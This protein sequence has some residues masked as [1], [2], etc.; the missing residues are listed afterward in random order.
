MGDDTADDNAALVELSRRLADGLARAGLTR[1]QLVARTGVKRTTVWSALR[2]KE[3][4]PSARTVAALARALRLPEKELL[5]LRRTAD[6]R[7]GAALA[8]ERASGPVPGHLVCGR[9]IHTAG[10]G[11]HGTEEREQDGQISSRK[12]FTDRSAYFFSW[13]TRPNS[14]RRV[15][16]GGTCEGWGTC[17]AGRRSPRHG[18][19]RRSTR[20]S[21]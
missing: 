17:G 14:S 20:P 15:S 9:P 16:G 7:C 5:E 1:D 18:M 21:A 6:G 2:G 8:D 3:P 4:V 11:E 13:R 10:A 12:W 19:L